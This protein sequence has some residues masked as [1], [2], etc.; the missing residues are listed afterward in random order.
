MDA[1]DHF[2]AE[3]DGTVDGSE[4]KKKTP[5]FETDEFVAFFQ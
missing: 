5:V 2:E 3:N 1:S 4:K